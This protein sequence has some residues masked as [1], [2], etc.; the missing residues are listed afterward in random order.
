MHNSV[1]TKYNLYKKVESENQDE[2][3]HF[4]LIE[5]VDY[6]NR[7]LTK[8]SDIVCLNETFASLTPS[9]LRCSILDEKSKPQA[10][11][12]DVIRYALFY[13]R[14]NKTEEELD[15]LNDTKYDWPVCYLNKVNSQVILEI[16]QFY[17]L[18][19]SPTEKVYPII[20]NYHVK[21]TFF[22][23]DYKMINI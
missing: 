3:N 6:G 19:L 10:I 21:S 7:Q 23:W 22:F 20:S 11:A 15:N 14:L 9:S 18:F 13:G 2:A 17:D 4:I 5:F 16:D 1:I 12:P 8:I